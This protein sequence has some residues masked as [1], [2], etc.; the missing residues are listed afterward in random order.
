MASA[1]G[2]DLP[3]AE[4]HASM[5]VDIGGGTTEVAVISLGGMVVA[6]SI[7]VAGDELTE[8]IVQYFRKKYN[9]TDRIKITRFFLF[10]L[11]FRTY[12]SHISMGTDYIL[13]ARN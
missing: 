12:Y 7:D 4:P 8:C 3:V 2:A 6:K 1:M 13:L 9:L 11:S 10:P 5:I